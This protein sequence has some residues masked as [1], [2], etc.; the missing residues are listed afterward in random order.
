AEVVAID[1]LDPRRWDWPPGSRDDVVAAIGARMGSGEGFEIVMR[2]LGR[3]VERRELSVY[4]LDPAAVGT[5]D[6]V[7][8]GSLLLHLRDPVLALE[9]VR[10][11]CAGE[12]VVVDSIDP[13]LTLRHPRRPLA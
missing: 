7:Y 6:F 3:Q 1:V 8:V 9:R 4:D 11:V 5:F 2:A 12:A 10:G 13:V